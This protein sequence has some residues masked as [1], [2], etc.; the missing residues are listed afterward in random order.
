MLMLALTSCWQRRQSRCARVA[1]G[2][3]L[4]PDAYHEIAEARGARP[5][6]LHARLAAEGAKASAVP[7]AYAEVWALLERKEAEV[8]AAEVS[9]AELEAA[10][11]RLRRHVRHSMHVILQENNPESYYRDVT[12]MRPT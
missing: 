9:E 2:V 1:G 3:V 11:A 12:H 7:E 5:E 8:G 6:E 10:H 4:H